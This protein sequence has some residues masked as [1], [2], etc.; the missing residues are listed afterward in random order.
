MFAAAA[1]EVRLRAETQSFIIFAA[2]LFACAAI[3]A[4][5]VFADA[6]ERDSDVRAILSFGVGLIAA[7]AL[8]S[9]LTFLVT[10]RHWLLAIAAAAALVAAGSIAAELV[11]V[12]SLAKIVFGA[13]AGLWISLMI[14]S[15]GQVVLIA[16][17]IILVDFYSVFLGP[18][19]RMVESG[20]PWLDHLTISLPTMGLDAASRLGISDIIFFSL[21]IGCTLCF[22]LRRVTTALAMTVS[23]LGTMVVGVI[24]D[25]GVPALPLM[26][27]AFLLANADLL[28]RRFLE[29]PDKP[30]R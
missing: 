7:A 25:I 6:I 15:V 23:L 13:S 1:P 16:V 30:P 8:A 21:F 9:S 12:E 11:S 29:E 3:L 28:Y 19:R 4:A 14:T 2:V 24:L 10:L 20:S 17:L 27:V 22:S 5:L 18:T 26:S